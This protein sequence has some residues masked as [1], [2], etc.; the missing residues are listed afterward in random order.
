LRAAEEKYGDDLVVLFVDE[1]E[2]VQDVNAFAARYGLESVFVMDTT[3]SVGVDY[4]LFS[5]PTTYIV[6]ADGVIRNIQA[7]VIN[8]AWLDSQMAA[9]SQ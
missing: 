4:R 2:S 8:L 9:L 5:T 1:E 7:G 3:G 6:D